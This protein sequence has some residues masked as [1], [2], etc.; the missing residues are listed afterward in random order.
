M[1]TT[2]S[3]LRTAAAGGPTRRPA[4]FLAA[5]LGCLLCVGFLPGC[6]ADSP[7]TE[8]TAPTSPAPVTTPSPNGTETT[9]NGTETT[10]LAPNDLAACGQVRAAGA[11]LS[12]TWQRYGQG[13]APLSEV[14]AAAENLAATAK[15]AASSAGSALRSQAEELQTAAQSFVNTLKASP[16]PPRQEI[17]AEAQRL[18]QA[19]Q[20]VQRPCPSPSS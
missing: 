2:S 5:L 18:F 20:A 6:G 8:S 10:G 11:T 1:T 7:G 17:Q 15:T 14:V 3:G 9:P 19:L 16:R 13:Q 12:D 4:L